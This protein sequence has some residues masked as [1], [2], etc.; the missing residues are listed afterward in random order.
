MSTYVIAEAGST[1]RNDKPESR[2]I[3]YAVQAIQVAKAAGADAVKF[4]F[5]SDPTLM[6][7]RRHVSAGTY[8][9]LH[10]S[11]SWLR[12]LKRTADEAK[13]DFLCT[14]FLAKDVPV[15]A[16]YVAKFK[17]ASL[18]AGDD[19]LIETCL[20]WGKPVIVSQGCRTA[21]E[22][23]KQA[24]RPYVTGVRW[25]QCTAAYPAPIDALGLSMIKDID[26]EFD[27]L[28][29]HSGDVLTGA[30]AVAC[31]AEIIEVHFRLDGTL[32][33]N[34]DYAHSHSPANLKVY[35]D[36]V[37]KAER[38]LGDGVKKIEPCEEPMRKH[39]VTA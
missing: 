20:E 35:I 37:R 11:E 18:E 14:V 23:L 34:P 9:I 30:I 33:S 21:E 36:N 1:W 22:L 29:D 5:C 28:S 12:F 24:T 6:E 17:I 16:P 2:H 19:E 39:R 4:Q 8:S 38:M 31:G 3:D 13:I 10:W 32:K 26:F 15:V 27:G 7:Q 25:L